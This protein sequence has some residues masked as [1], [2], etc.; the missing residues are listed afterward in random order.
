MVSI[1]TQPP[2]GEESHTP[3]HARERTECDP[4]RPVSQIPRLR[5]ELGTGVSL[6]GLTCFCV[7]GSWLHSWLKVLKGPTPPSPSNSPVFQREF[8]KMT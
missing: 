3:P 1:G 6:K 4:P 5:L 7:L 8:A 2:E